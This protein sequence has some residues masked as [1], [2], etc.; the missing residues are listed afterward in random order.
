MT[1]RYET[2]I[3]EILTRYPVRSRYDAAENRLTAALA[4]VLMRS[5]KLA[6]ELARTWGV[7]ATRPVRV[8]P[9]APTRGPRI[10]TID[11]EARF[12]TGDAQSVVWI[13]AKL[14]S[15]LSGADQL[16]RYAE[17]L[18]RVSA[19][20]RLLVL[21]APAGDRSRF[22]TVTPIA[23]RNH[24]HAS[25]K[26]YFVS[27]QQVYAFL[28]EHHDRD[29]WFTKEV[30]QY[31]KHVGVQQPGALTRSTLRA[32]ELADQAAASV[33]AI[34]D[35]AAD[36]LPD[37]WKADAAYGYEVRYRPPAGH[38][39]GRETRFV[40][41]VDEPGQPPATYYAG[42]IWPAGSK[43]FSGP[44]ALREGWQARLVDWESDT[45]GT[46]EWIWRA[47]R[48]RDL[49][50]LPTPAEQGQCV[51][52]HAAATFELLQASRITT[53]SDLC[54]GWT[55]D[56]IREAVLT[57]TDA[58]RDVLGAI[59]SNPGISTDEIAQILNL[60]SAR[61][62]GATM[63]AWSRMVTSPMGVTDTTGTPSWPIEFPGPKAGYETYLMPPAVA[64]VVIAALRL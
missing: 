29:D 53:S 16:D 45:Y 54:R 17:D 7:P 5:P 10:G 1:D 12:G 31:M 61:S 35:S 6:C 38:R 43:P 42:I 51:A 55:A 41:G 57:A 4:A 49:I 21:L 36:A 18:A 28:L 56:A 58:Q 64:R 27:W 20:H 2:N 9:Q 26:A 48:L 34:V 63:A 15:P 13:E 47:R 11:L 8:K 62:V 25:I 23:A 59:A 60:K 37:H 19:G 22:A 52:D 24:G 46:E 39:W 3:I 50:G 44:R 14:H 32:F 30:L 40:M 33:A